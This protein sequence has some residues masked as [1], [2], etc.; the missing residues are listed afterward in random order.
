AHSSGRGAEAH[1]CRTVPGSRCRAGRVPWPPCTKRHC[2]FRRRP[3]SLLPLRRLE[4]PRGRQRCPPPALG[5]S[6][7]ELVGCS[8]GGAVSQADTIPV[9]DAVRTGLLVWISDMEDMARRYPRTSLV[10]PYAFA[11]AAAPLAAR[12][13][14]VGGLVLLWPAA[15][16]TRLSGVE[17]AVID[18]GC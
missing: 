16:Q 6:I 12:G 10:L 1:R 18:A 15:H 14:V 8:I 9:A 4:V 11:L 13:S 2:R 5:G 17:R 7:W 3:G